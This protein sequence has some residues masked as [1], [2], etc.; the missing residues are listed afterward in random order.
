[1]SDTKSEISEKVQPP[2][3][4]DSGNQEVKRQLDEVYSFSPIIDEKKIIGTYVKEYKITGFIGEGGMGRVLAGIHPRIGKK[5]AIK[6]LKPEYY[7]NET[8]ISRFLYEAQAVN[9]IRHPNIVDIFDF[10]EF[11]DGTHYFIMEYV[12]GETLADYLKREIFC[13]YQFILDVMLPIIDALT[14]AHSKHVIHRD[15]K[16]DNI[17]ITKLGDGR[18]F[19]K[20]LDFG[21]AKFTETSLANQQTKSGIPIGTPI[22]MPPEQ[23]AGKDMDERSDIYALGI[24][25]YQMVTGTIPFLGSNFLTIMT[26]QLTQDPTPPSTYVDIPPKLEKLILWCMSKNKESRPPSAME[27]KGNLESILQKA[28][29]AQT[30]TPVK[31]KDYQIPD[32]AEF[33]ISA[34]NNTIIGQVRD[35]KFHRRAFYVIL[36]LFILTIGGGLFLLRDRLFPATPYEMQNYLRF[37][38]IADYQFHIPTPIKTA[39]VPDKN[40]EVMIQLQVDPLNAVCNIFVDGKPQASPVF[41]LPRNEKEAIELKVSAQG[42]KTWRQKIVP[43]FSQNIPV[44]LKKLDDSENPKIKKVDIPDVL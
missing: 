9:D 41:R 11:E 33:S 32:I 13:S 23:C 37:A 12:E 2:E 18:I 36:I 5:V 10:A 16:P 29:A 4:A 35:A 7:N 38:S 17:I 40:T 27:V 26:A 14:Q 6:I 20:L 8:T 44:I 34:Y 39:A 19:P 30:D 24:I 21:I 3:K 15:L 28:I 42:F 1:M 43:A 31:K 25:L 22:Y